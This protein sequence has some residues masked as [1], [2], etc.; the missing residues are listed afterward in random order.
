MK[1]AAGGESPLATLRQSIGRMPL[2]VRS[3][4]PT[5]SLEHLGQ[6]DPAF[7]ARHG[8]AGLIWDIDGTLTAYHATRLLPSAEAPFAALRALPGLR[9]AILSNAPEWRFRELAAM[10]PDIPV[11]RGYRVAGRVIGRRLLGT[12]DSLT[13]GELDHHLASGAM[14]LRKPH[15]ELVRLAIAELGCAAELVAMVGDQYLTDVAG[16][17]LAG[18]RSIKLPNPAP[19][20]F[21]WSIRFTQQLE[22]LLFRLRPR[23]EP[24]SSPGRTPDASS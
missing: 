3:M 6:L 13:A 9:H 1:R 4:A 2:L 20:S 8:I 19:G 22:R 15:A 17:N 23:A 24:T 7:I 11:L 14:T 5:W 10:F 16:A 12:A 21:P 18:V